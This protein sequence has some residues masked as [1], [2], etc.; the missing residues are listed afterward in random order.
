MLVMISLACEAAPAA[1]FLGPTS[2]VQG[3]RGLGVPGFRGDLGFGFG[4][5]G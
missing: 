5:G 2:G 3:F 4:G 1:N